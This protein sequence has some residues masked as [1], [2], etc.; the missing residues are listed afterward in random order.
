[1]YHDETKSNR[2]INFI[3]R[4]C[5][6]VKGDLANQPFL[7]EQWQKDYIGQLFGTMNDN[8]QRQYRTSYVQI[9]RKNGK[10]NLLA[11]VALAMLFVEKEA[12]AEIYCCASSRDQANAIFD[13]CKQMVRNKAVLTNGC[14]VF[15]NSIVLNGTNSFLKAVASDAGVLHGANASCV[16]Y[17]EVHTAKSRELW[18]VMATSMGARS[19][20]LMFGISTAGL[21]DPNSVC[22]ELYD[23]G[24]KVRDGVIDDKTFLPCIYEAAPDDDIHDPDVWKKA[25]P[26]FGVSIKPEYFEKMSREAKSLPSAEIAFRQLHL[27][28]WVNSLSGWI[29]D[30]EWMKST[31]DI[32]WDQLRGR[33]CY[34]GLDLAATEDVCAFVL[35]F[36]FDDGSIK[37]V[38]KLFVSEAA[39]ERRRNQT[40]GSYDTFV[41]NGELIVTEGNS[42]DYAVIERT[43]KECAD[44]Y[45]IKSIAFDRWNSNSLVQS[46]TDAGLE[47]DPFGQGFISMTAPIKNAEILVKKRL[48]HHGGHGMMR[49]MVANVVTKKDDAENIKFSKAKAGDKI[50]GIIAMVMALGEMI[51][52]ENKDVTGSST[53]ES[54]GIRML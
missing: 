40:G 16:L 32:P 31:G 25:N 15:R 28:Q 20:P 23:Y 17:D 50:D 41:A 34:A 52:M 8:G 26:N 47:M 43:I 14:K 2:I 39:V 35:I 12:G 27:N 33:D 9:P 48:L 51:T 45:N 24:K 3:E 49:W 5:T 44:A 37:V 53:Y 36:P 1:M 6:H 38:P 42:T 21:F 7:L 10:S 30:D 13:V 19:Q 18:D 54:Q 22:Y 29:P 11:A 4:V 46:L